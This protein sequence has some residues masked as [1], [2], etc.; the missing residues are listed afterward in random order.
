MCPPQETNYHFPKS[1]VK[2]LE[3]MSHGLSHSLLPISEPVPVSL[4]LWCSNWPSLG[5]MPRFALPGDGF[6]WMRATTPCT[7][8]AEL[9]RECFLMENETVTTKGR[10]KK[11]WEGKNNSRCVLQCG[12]GKAICAFVSQ[13]FSYKIKSWSSFQ[14]HLL[15]T[16]KVKIIK[17]IKAY[18]TS[19]C[20]LYPSYI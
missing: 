13:K 8:W 14:M 1:V 12:V 4:R 18:L 5:H 17:T 9:V 16:S 11:C 3:S 20:I 15:Y 19:P 6:D 10:R 7:T 2:K